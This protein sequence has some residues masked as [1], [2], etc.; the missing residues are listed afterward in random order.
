MDPFQDDA[1]LHSIA[2]G[3]IAQ[4]KVNVDDAKTVG[5]RPTSNI[6][7]AVSQAQYCFC[8]WCFAGEFDLVLAQI[9]RRIGPWL[10]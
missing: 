5:E 8:I 4:M 2:T 3:V 10:A 9:F 6:L 1:T 7:P